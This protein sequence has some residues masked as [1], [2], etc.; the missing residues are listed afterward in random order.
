M[1]NRIGSK[2]DPNALFSPGEAGFPRPFGRMASAQVLL[3]PTPF[4][5]RDTL[6]ERAVIGSYALSRDD[7]HLRM[8][9]IET[10]DLE[11]ALDDHNLGIRKIAETELEMEWAA[12]SGSIMYVPNTRY[13][14]QRTTCV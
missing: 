14:W 4:C 6:H 10:V 12:R 2:F 9:G 3:G 8:D 5:R 11:H 1:N 7:V 13:V